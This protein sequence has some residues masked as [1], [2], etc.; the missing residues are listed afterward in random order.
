MKVIEAQSIVKSFSKRP[1]LKDLDLN[2]EKG[3]IYT[4]FGSNGVGK[5]TLIRIL[6]TLSRQDSGE[7]KLFGRTTEDDL[8][9]IRQNLGLVAHDKSLYGD[10]TARE[11]LEFFGELYSVPNK[12]KKIK[13]LLHEAGLFHRSHD[14]VGTF[15]KGMVQRLAIARAVIHDPKLVL[16][17]EPYAGLDIKAR[18][19]LNDII[20]RLN[21]GGTSFLIITHDL[22]TGFDVAT[23]CGLLQNGKIVEECKA[24]DKKI[25]A[26][27]FGST[28][29]GG[30][31]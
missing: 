12:G 29:R 11:N 4:L 24:S 1:V 28:I 14:L 30:I 7:L 15:S 8:I 20:S 17:D 10:L 19:T 25:F 27:K 9:Y 3:E 21:R 2:L 26:K 16:M 23:R 6:A 13:E 18:E 5:T 31:C 22:D